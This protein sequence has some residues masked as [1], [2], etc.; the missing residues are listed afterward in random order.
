MTLLPYKAW[1]A[2]SFFKQCNLHETKTKILQ[3]F[4]KSVKPEGFR[5]YPKLKPNLFAAV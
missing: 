2:C 5:E 3:L 4:K 1:N